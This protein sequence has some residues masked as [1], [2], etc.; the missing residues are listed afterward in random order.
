MIRSWGSAA[1][2]LSIPLVGR[3]VGGWVGWVGLSGWVGWVGGW[4]EDAR[5]KHDSK[6]GISRV[7]SFYTPGKR[8]HPPTHP[9]L[10]SSTSFE[11]PS[12]PLPTHPRTQQQEEQEHQ[13]TS[14]RPTHPL[15]SRCLT[16]RSGTRGIM[17]RETTC[18]R[19]PLSRGPSPTHPPTHPL[20]HPPTHT[21]EIHSWV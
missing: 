9:T 13:A 17:G 20:T 14:V 2:P 10:A 3:W 19:S 1:S 16:T 8:A 15:T 7:S 18:T 4:N 6:L 11:P 21:D 5:R 12:F